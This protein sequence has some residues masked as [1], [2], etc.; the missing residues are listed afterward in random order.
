MVKYNYKIGPAIAQNISQYL[1]DV[2]N[3]TWFV[4]ISSSNVSSS[5]KSV[6]KDP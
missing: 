4:T 6:H 3:G 2:Y 1:T 5:W